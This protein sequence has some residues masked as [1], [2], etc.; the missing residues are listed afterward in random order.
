MMILLYR[1]NC[2]RRAWQF[3][4]YRKHHIAAGVSPLILVTSLTIMKY[5]GGLTCSAHCVKI[6]QPRNVNKLKPPATRHPAAI[7]DAFHNAECLTVP[8]PSRKKFHHGVNT[9]NHAISE[10][11]HSVNASNRS[12]AL[13]YDDDDADDA[14]DDWTINGGVSSEEEGGDQETRYKAARKRRAA[15]AAAKRTRALIRALCVR[16]GGRSKAAL[17]ANAVCAALSTARPQFC[18]TVP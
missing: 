9:S 11:Y 15:R 18:L 16:F 6:A 1:R 17:I 5:F 4:V 12:R 8:P 3:T 2:L 7:P 10:Y 14:D 13:F